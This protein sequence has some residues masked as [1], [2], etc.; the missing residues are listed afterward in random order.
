[1]GEQIPKL[2]AGP[3]TDFSVS[4]SISPTYP[5]P[6]AITLLHLVPKPLSYGPRFRAALPV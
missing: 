6:T 3:I 1:M 4:V 5:N 2:T